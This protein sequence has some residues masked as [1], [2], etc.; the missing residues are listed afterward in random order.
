MPGGLEGPGLAREARQLRP[1][2]KVL[3]T[4]GFPG[5]ESKASTS[6]DDGD[7]LLSKPYRRTELART[8]HRILNAA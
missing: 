2:L 6:L 4:S 1:G 5:T 8:I 7:E 3:F